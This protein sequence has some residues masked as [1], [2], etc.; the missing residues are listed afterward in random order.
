[1]RLTLLRGAIL[2]ASILIVASAPVAP[3]GAGAL[4]VT[5]FSGTRLHVDLTLYGVPQTQVFGVGDTP[6]A[7]RRIPDLWQIGPDA[8]TLFANTNSFEPFPKRTASVPGVAWIEPDSDPSDLPHARFNALAFFLSGERG[9]L[10]IVVASD[11]DYDF[12]EHHIFGDDGM[13]HGIGFSNNCEFNGVGH[14]QCPITLTNGES[15]T[16]P[17]LNFDPKFDRELV[18]TFTDY[19]DSGVPIPEPATW[20]LLVVGLAALAGARAK[21]RAR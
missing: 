12:L 7:D 4:T 2:A 21:R 20:T 14:T 6:L 11:L 8:L 17:I 3:A 18:L 9:T 19:G 15:Y 13:G 10:T 1:M 5:E 16:I